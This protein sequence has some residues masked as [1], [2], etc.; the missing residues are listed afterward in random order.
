[1]K[2]LWKRYVWKFAYTYDCHLTVGLSGGRAFISRYY[3]CGCIG[4]RLSLKR[5]RSFAGSCGSKSGES[6]FI[7]HV[8][9]KSTYLAGNSGGRT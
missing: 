8:G 2:A 6:F 9:S 1:V 7:T 4:G 3:P 5:T